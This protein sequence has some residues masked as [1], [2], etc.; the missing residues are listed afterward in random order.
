MILARDFGHLLPLGK[1]YMCFVD[2][3]DKYREFFSMI[4]LTTELSCNNLFICVLNGASP[5]VS[6]LHCIPPDGDAIAHVHMQRKLRD[7]N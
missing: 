4:A 2:E 7:V 6:Q 3:P 5:S 1:E